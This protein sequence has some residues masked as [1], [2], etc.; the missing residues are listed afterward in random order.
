MVDYSEILLSINTSMKEV[1]HLLLA[2]NKEAAE[3][4]LKAV[5]ASAEMLAAWI[6]N[7]K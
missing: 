6:H 5:A 3:G 4:Y 7:N 1:H 2:G